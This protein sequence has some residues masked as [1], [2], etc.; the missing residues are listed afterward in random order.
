MVHQPLDAVP[1]DNH[2]G[3]DNLGVRLD[4]HHDNNDI[5]VLDRL[6]LIIFTAFTIIAT[7]AVLSAAPHVIVT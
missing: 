4:D 6:C 2:H 3:P 7:V 5:Q 1:D